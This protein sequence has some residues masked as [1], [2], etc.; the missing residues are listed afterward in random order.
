[1][2]TSGERVSSLGGEVTY[3]GRKLQSV[4]E[5]VVSDVSMT[6]I[7]QSDDEITIEISALEP[8]NYSVELISG[9]GRITVLDALTVYLEINTSTEAPNF[10]TKRISDTE[11]KVYA[12]NAVGIGKVQFI[13]NGQEIAWVR[14]TD[15][16]HSKL[17]TVMLNGE[18]VS[19][20]VR[21][22][23]VDQKVRIEIRLNGDR[24]KAATY[25]PR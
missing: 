1:L 12:K 7:A 8:G 19:Y 5:V 21:T 11:V 22:V 15:P 10:V 17:R 9:N 6:I 14:T 20:L 3:Q 23:I 16:Q 18:E 24:E 25:N 2:E 4:N 13:V